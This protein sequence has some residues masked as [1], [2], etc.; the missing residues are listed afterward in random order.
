VGVA[1]AR[2]RG[3]PTRA[4]AGDAH[5]AEAE[6][7]ITL[8]IDSLLTHDDHALVIGEGLI[9][10]SSDLGT[11]AAGIALAIYAHQSRQ[12]YLTMPVSD[13]TA[14][15]LRQKPLPPTPEPDSAPHAANPAA[16]PSHQLVA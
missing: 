16:A 7:Q 15:L 6:R 2:P 3:S 12:P 1:W 11:G 8:V 5:Q 14:A 9:R 13:R 10:L 4:P